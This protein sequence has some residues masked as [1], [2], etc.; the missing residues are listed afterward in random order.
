[1]KI[2]IDT[3]ILIDNLRGGNK[4]NEFFKNT[5]E[6]S[7]LFLPTIVV[8]EL[9]LGSSSKNKTVEKKIDNFRK[10]FREVE[11]SWSIAKRGAEI[12]RD[13]TQNIDAADC[14][15]AGTAFEVGGTV[16]TLNKKHFEKIPG[17]ALYSF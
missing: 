14:I 15:I 4:W 11:L 2:V 9:F 10:Y 7:Q 1:M 13:Q 12:Y 16:L 17:L 5:D 3:S 8:F 6:D